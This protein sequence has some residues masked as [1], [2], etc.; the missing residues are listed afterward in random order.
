MSDIKYLES[1]DGSSSLQ[2]RERSLESAD[3]GDILVYINGA[4]LPR[5]DAKISVFD[6]SFQSG[7]NVWEGLRV[8]Q[9]RVFELEAHIKRLYESAKILDIAVHLAPQEI[10]EAV[11]LT[12]RANQLFDDTHIRLILSRGERRTSGMNPQFVTG[13]ATLVIIAE[14]KP[15]IY[16]KQGIRLATSSVRRPAPDSL[17]P[18]IHHG[19]QLNSIIAK[20]EANRNGV[21]DALMLDHHGFVAETSS[22]NIFLVKDGSVATPLPTAC[23]PGITRATVIRECRSAGLAIEERSLTLADFYVADEAF[24][25]GTIVEI[26]PVV[27]IDGRPVGDGA[28]GVVTLR[29]TDIYAALTRTEGVPIN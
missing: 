17:N 26:V 10:Q 24:V 20:L 5:Q 29:L 22:M 21:D 11:L 1:I 23:L 28:P 13:P 3:S 4:L 2:S 7:D 14:R 6:A 15:P 18:L 9:G 16:S 8:Y 27:E 25:T 12:L 19:N